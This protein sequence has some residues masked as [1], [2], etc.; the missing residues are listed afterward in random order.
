MGPFGNAVLGIIFLVTGIATTFLM[1]RLW[2]Y[3]FDHER[4]KSEAP[5]S[6]MLLHRVLGYIYAAAYIYLMIQMVP[7]L[8]SYQIELPP[9]T[10]LHLALGMAVGAILL[11]KCIIVRFFKHLEGT[12]APFLG[13]S[14]LVATVVLVGLSAPIA[15]REAYAFRAGGSLG[16]TSREWV[17]AQLAT[18]GLDDRSKCDGLTSAGGLRAGRDVLYTKCVACHDLR[19]VLA[20]PRTAQNWRE[21]VLRMADRAVMIS[22]ISEQEQWHVTAYLIAISPD[23]QRSAKQQRDQQQREEQT[24]VAVQES[25]SGGAKSAGDP[26][27]GR[28]LFETRCSQCHPVAMVEANPPRSADAVQKILTRMVKNGLSANQEELVLIRQHLTERFVK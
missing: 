3:P 6:L 12:L 26:A 23:L 11:V 4:H 1:Y 16:A 20:R 24:R 22:P 19:T 27:R 8:W 15:L 28:Q 18:A 7:R 10:V 9:R 13:T 25:P 17:S 14:L 5:P 21:T 2:G